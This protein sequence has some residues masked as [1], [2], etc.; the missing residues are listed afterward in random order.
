MLSR[1]FFV[2][3]VLTG[4]AGCTSVETTEEVP[5]PPPAVLAEEYRIGVSD[6]L[7]VN[8]W[9]NPDLSVSVGVRPDGKV[10]VPLVGDVMA[11]GKT[12]EELATEV[13]RKMGGF[14]RNPEVTVIVVSPNSATYLRLVRVTGAVN[15]PQSIPYAQGMTVLDVVLQAGGLTPFAVANGGLLYRQ[16]A[17]GVKAYPVYVKDILKK[18]KLD[19]NYELAP[20]DVLTIPERKF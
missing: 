20:S 7:S 4:F 11:A 19:T 12:A 3:V 10:S 17:Q 8:V 15:S 13:T 18:G 5:V 9:R 1:V 16:T 6:Q 14:V 2:M